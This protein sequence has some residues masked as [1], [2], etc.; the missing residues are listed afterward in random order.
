MLTVLFSLTPRKTKD[1]NVF[2]VAFVVQLYS[3]HFNMAEPTG[4]NALLASL[5]RTGVASQL[6]EA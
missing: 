2:C 4:E 1:K 3:I 5:S 6:L